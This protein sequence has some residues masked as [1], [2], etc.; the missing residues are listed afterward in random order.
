MNPLLGCFLIGVSLSLSFY[1]AKALECGTDTAVSLEP[2]TVF[3]AGQDNRINAFACLKNGFG[4]ADALTTCTFNAIFPVSGHLSLK[5]GT[6]ALDTDLH[7]NNKTVFASGGY[8]RGQHHMFTLC[9]SVTEFPSSHQIIL[10]NVAIYLQHDLALS[11]TLI[12]RGDCSIYGGDNNINLGDD[13]AIVIDHESSLLLSS[14]ELHGVCHCN[15]RCANDSGNLILDH[16]RLVQTCDYTFTQG[17]IL[18]R[19]ENQFVGPYVFDYE[20][21]LTSTVATDSS[22]YVADLAKLSFGNQRGRAPLYFVDQSSMLKIENATL[23]IKHDGF[24]MTRGTFLGSREV[25]L[26]VNSTNLSQAFSMGNGNSSEDAY[27]KLLPGSIL[28]HT[29]GHFIYNIV[30]A[31]NFFTEGTTMIFERYPGTTFE[32]KRSTH[33]DS[34]YSKIIGSPL[35]TI[36]DPGVK[37]TYKGA[38]FDLPNFSYTLTGSRPVVSYDLLDTGDSVEIYSGEYQFSILSVGRGTMLRGTGSVRG[39]IVLTNPAAQLTVA[40]DGPV[41]GGVQLNGGTLFCQRDIFFGSNAIISG[42]GRVLLQ[43][44]K[45]T[46]DGMDINYNG[47]LSWTGNQGTVELLGDMALSSH[48]TFT[49]YC[50]LQ[51]NNCEL[52]FLPTGKITVGSNSTLHIKNNFLSRVRDGSLVLTDNSSKIILDDT[53]ITLAQNITFSTGSMEIRNNVDFSGSY[54]FYYTS[55]I[56]STITKHAQLGMIGGIALVTGRSSLPAGREPFYFEERSS[57]ISF[58]DA[59]LV[60]TSS[61]IRFA[62]G[63]GVVNKQLHVDMNSTGSANGIIFGH[64]RP[65]EDFYLKINPGASWYLPT[66]D[67]GYE[68]TDPYGI[69]SVTTLANIYNND[70]AIIH[71]DQNVVLKDLTVVFNGPLQTHFH[72]NAVLWYE[73]ATFSAPG[74]QF[75]LTG[76][77]YNDYTNLLM[78]GSLYI[79]TGVL[80]LVTL[81]AGTGNIMS[82]LGGVSQP[83]I[84]SDRYTQLTIALDSMIQAPI[85]IQDSTL[86]LGKSLTLGDNQLIKGRGIVN[87][88]GNTLEIGGLSLVS[89]STLD[90]VA[91]KGALKLRDNLLLTSRWTF[92]GEC[93]LQGNGNSLILGPRGQIA[94]APRSTLILKNI[95]VDGLQEGKLYCLDNS[96]VFV[97][98]GTICSLDSSLS[99]TLGAFKIINQSSIDGENAAFAYESC[100]TSSIADR[101][102][103]TINSDVMF[104]YA[105]SCD[106]RKLIVL[107]GRNSRLSLRNAELH[108]TSTG[109]QLTKGCVEIHGQCRVSSDALYPAEGILLG[110]GLSENDDIQLDIYPESIMEITSGYLVNK[111]VV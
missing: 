105:P 91:Q 97:F 72:N 7:L 4:L 89:T 80:P 67:L 19:D 48:W 58:D 60:I 76:Q 107:E 110:N 68:V 9:E 1:Q 33:F 111:N 36:I 92:S 43:K 99:F 73:N 83:I 90:F 54:S 64:N 94:L 25:T 63:T 47:S 66:G 5:G 50:V 84:L 10:E 87:V 11:G 18:F 32:I 59:T 95:K 69:Q 57:T 15:V 41:M 79:E 30:S 88:Q 34:L 24:S 29:K 14:L 51:G 70:R 101:S 75:K 86:L 26:E 74:L 106:K 81:V 38:R 52:T 100:M 42:Q 37:L 16:V 13:G 20:S 21:L 93:T 44:S 65:E 3:S 22:F 85:I 46:F 40:F 78:N 39:P 102:R 28:R 62:R 45:V 108:S 12:I 6:L 35:T 109:L 49:G 2:Y 55:C 77:R 103:L 31:P 17:S 53:M 104:S 71:L 56:T 27:M 98:D 23:A 8:L 96:S 61:G 82:G